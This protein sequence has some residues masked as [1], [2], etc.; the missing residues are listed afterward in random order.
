MRSR[1]G[2][3]SNRGSNPAVAYHRETPLLVGPLRLIWSAVA[4]TPL[5]RHAARRVAGRE[6][7]SARLRA[8]RNRTT[9]RVVPTC[10]V[11]RRRVEPAVESGVEPPQSKTRSRGS[12]REVR[13][14]SVETSSNFRL[15]RRKHPVRGNGL[16]PPVVG[17]NSSTR[18]PARSIADH[19][20]AWRKGYA[21]C[22][23]RDPRPTSSR[24]PKTRS[25][26]AAEVMAGRRCR[27]ARSSSPASEV[28]ITPTQLR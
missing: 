25:A 7:G 2:C 13:L 18:L 3:L 4:S 19:T 20:G 12:A 14:A 26:L 10:I 1:A 22:L 28:S 23:T 8:L 9:R 27:R 11:R 24:R 17:S 15:L 16:S 5:S 21:Y 6:S